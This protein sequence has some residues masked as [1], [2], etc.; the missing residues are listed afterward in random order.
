MTIPGVDAI[1]ATAIAA[2]ASPIEAFRK[3]RDFTAW[4][5]PTPVQRS[6]GGKQKLGATSKPFASGPR[7]DLQAV[8]G[9]LLCK[10]V[11][12]SSRLF[13]ILLSACNRRG[14]VMSMILMFRHGR[15]A[16]LGRRAH[17][18]LGS[19]PVSLYIPTMGIVLRLDRDA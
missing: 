6:T 11:H 10:P 2:L 3:G 14:E 19:Q 5:G 4:L 9:A 13:V 15:N 12:S 17:E 18:W 1:T 16:I 8:L 7:L